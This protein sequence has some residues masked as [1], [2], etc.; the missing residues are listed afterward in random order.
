MLFDDKQMKKLKEIEIDMLKKFVSICEQLGL[1]YYLIGGTLL[2]AVRHKG[3]IPWDD[4]IDVGMPRQDYEIFVEKAGMF[5][6]D[7]I[8]LQNFRTDKNMIFPFTKLRNVNTTYIETRSKYSKMNQGVWMD[9]F[10]LDY[11]EL[12]E[13]KRNYQ[14]RK[15]SIINMRI[16]MEQ[17]IVHNKDRSFARKAIKKIAYKIIKMMYPTLTSAVKRVDSIYS[18]TA[19]SDIWVNKSGA[20]P[21]KE[22]VPIEWFGKGC[23]VD[24]ENM[25]VSAPVEYDKYLKHIYGDY[26]TPPPVEKQVSVHDI[27]VIDLEKSYKEY[28][29]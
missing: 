5:L 15:V 8:F 12:N 24:F 13:L 2:G 27:E 28:I 3:F 16:G 25:K 17:Y 23:Y 6:P 4:D 11:Y 19:P 26:M 22:E 1:K 18:S 14:I 29:K 21:G 7:Y 20:Y 9:I 10:P